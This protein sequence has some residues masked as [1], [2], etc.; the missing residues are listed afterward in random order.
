M[1]HISSLWDEKHQ[2]Q[3]L[4]K[5]KGIDFAAPIGTP[6]YAGGNGIVE[7]VGTNGGYGK[8]IRIVTIMNIKQHM[9]I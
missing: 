9:P 4:T 8:Y 3:V 1:V 7:Y 5:C 2:S 6:I